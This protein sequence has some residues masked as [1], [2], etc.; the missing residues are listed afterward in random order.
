MA[1]DGIGFG[2]FE[3]AFC[4][5]GVVGVAVGMREFG[6]FVERAESML[7]VCSHGLE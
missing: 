2:D 4:G 5:V 1:E 3:E 6:E 7:A